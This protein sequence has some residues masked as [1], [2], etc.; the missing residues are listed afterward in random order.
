MSSLDPA[1]P[2]AVLDEPE[3]NGTGNKEIHFSAEEIGFL[4]AVQIIT[5]VNEAELCDFPKG[6]VRFHRTQ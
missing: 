1:S 5:L 4:R 2:I 3:R 6:G